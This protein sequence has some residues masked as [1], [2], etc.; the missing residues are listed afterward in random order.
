MLLRDDFEN[1]S[2]SSFDEG[3][4]DNAIY[5]F[6]DGTYTVQCKQPKLILWQTVRG[7]YGN[8]AFS[9]DTTLDG[10]QD[11]ATGLIFHYQDDKNF[12]I[13]TVAGDS[14][15]SLDMYKD[16]QLTKL[17]DWTN[18]P[19]INGPGQ[20][21]S[22]RVETEGDTIRLFANDKLL[23]EISDATFTRGKTAIAVNTFDDPNLTVTFDNL[24]IQAIK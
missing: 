1:P 9:V 12:Y 13:F 17:I 24:V 10:P 14:S 6:V 3:E 18:S 15:Y 19:I 22:L 2:N 5:K 8:A 11:S 21:N 20:L 4:T 7:D 16:D 23:D